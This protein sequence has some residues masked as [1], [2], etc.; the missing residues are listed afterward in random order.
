MDAGTGPAP[1]FKGAGVPPSTPAP[2]IRGAG[3]ACGPP[4]ELVD[5]RINMLGTS[6]TLP[7]HVKLFCDCDCDCDCDRDCD[8]DCDWH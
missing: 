4:W 6:W 3:A 2:G 8:C 7:R 5:R 1:G